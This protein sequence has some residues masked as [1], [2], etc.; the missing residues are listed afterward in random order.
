MLGDMRLLFN[1][2]RDNIYM[3]RAI[4]IEASK[5]GGNETC[6]CVG[7]VAFIF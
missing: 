6:M 1:R 2:G 5:K 3:D 7:I 4:E